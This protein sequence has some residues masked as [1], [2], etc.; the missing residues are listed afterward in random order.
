MESRF[1]P[2]GVGWQPPVGTAPPKSGTSPMYT[3]YDPLPEGRRFFP[4]MANFW[5]ATR[6]RRSNGGRPLHADGSDL[7]PCLKRMCLTFHPLFTVIPCG[8]QEAAERFNR[9]IC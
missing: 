2:V 4:L 6:A 7:S 1:R 8:Q 3:H 5:Y 9:G